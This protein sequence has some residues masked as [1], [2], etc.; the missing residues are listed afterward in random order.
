V[1][2][3]YSGGAVAIDICVP[4]EPSGKPAQV[5]K[6][7]QRPSG[8]RAHDCQGHS[9]IRSMGGQGPPSFVLSVTLE[10]TPRPLPARQA[11]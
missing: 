2:R 11:W 5:S 4:G 8:E 6:A 1:F 10:P 3:H 7:I 9:A